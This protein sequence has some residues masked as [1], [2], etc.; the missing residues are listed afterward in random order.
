MYWNCPY[1]PK[2][3][4]QGRR[5]QSGK[6]DTNTE[7]LCLPESRHVTHFYKKAMLPGHLTQG[8]LNWHKRKADA[9]PCL[10]VLTWGII[11]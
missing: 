6:E 9:M 8:C 5:V 2:K 10:Q 7:G 3:I 1:W 11:G 4:G